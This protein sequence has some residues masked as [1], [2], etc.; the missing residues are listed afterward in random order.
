MVS[1][2]YLWPTLRCRRE[3]GVSPLLSI[4]WWYLSSV[5][6]K[7]Y[8]CRVSA[9]DKGCRVY[10]LDPHPDAVSLYSGCTPDCTL[11]PKCINC[12]QPHSADS[13]LCPKWKTEKQIQEV[14]SNRNITYLEARKLIAPPISQSYSQAI[15]SSKVTATTT[16]D[17]NITKIKYPLLNLLQQHSSLLK[18]NISRSILSSSTSSAQADL[19]TST[20]PIAAISESEPV[21]PIPNNVPS[22]SNI[23]AFPSNSG[24]QLISAS[25][26]IQDTKLKSKSLSRKRKKRAA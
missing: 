18:P 16:T 12:S 3:A 7:R 9:A 10:P 14:K 21:N 23:S 22:T 13:K 25:T 6:P 17:E 5:S 20:S 2:E 24:V 26:S 11:E 8:C 4:G 15:K 19:L 1:W